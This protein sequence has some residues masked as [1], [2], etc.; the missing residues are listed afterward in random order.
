MEI[1]KRIVWA[2]V[3]CS[4]E[5]DG[6]K[7]IRGGGKKRRKWLE[8]NTFLKGFAFALKVAQLYHRGLDNA[9]ALKL[10]EH[11][12]LLKNLPASYDGFSMLH[13]TD[14]HFDANPGLDER[15]GGLIKDLDVDLFA[16]TGD[17]RA[18]TFGNYRQILAP[19]ERVVQSI[20]PKEGVVAILGNHDTVLMT[21]HFEK[22]GIRVLTNET[23][24]IYRDGAPL[25]V[26]GIDDVH[27]YYTE[28]AREALETTPQGVRVALIHSPEL[29][30]LAAEYGFD[31]YVTGHTHGGQVALPGG[32]PIVT[33]LSAGKHL[34]RAGFWRHGGVLGYTSSGAGTS[35]IPVRFNTRPEIT[36]FTFRRESSV[37]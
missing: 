27:Y 33:H 25:H 3:R 36:L 30:D 35:G 8:F 19:V 1:N 18:N 15:V 22:M 28:M 10:V 34:G 17:Y 12:V 4:M 5:A 37:T 23:L 32:T 2:A 21:D 26:T 9:R 7:Q 13:L 16:L 29:Y 24:T 6:L 20:R 31:F 14:P 11:E